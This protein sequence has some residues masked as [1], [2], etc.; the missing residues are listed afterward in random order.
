MAK[1]QLKIEVNPNAE[2]EKL[3]DITNKVDGTGTN[4]NLSNVSIKANDRGLY[5][6]G[7]MNSKG[8]ELLSFGEDGNL[9]F[10]QSGYLSS[11]GKDVGMLASEQKPDMFVWGVVPSNK[12]YNVKL[13]FTNAQNL[14]DIV[15]YGDRVANQFPTEAIIDNDKVIYNDDYRWAINLLTESDTHTIEFTKWNRSDYNACLTLVRVMLRYFDISKDSGLIEVES[16]S[17]SNSQPKDIYYGVIPNTGS[18]RVNDIGGE[19]KDLIDEGIIT[20]SKNN[21][22]IF[23]DNQK[24]QHHITTDSDYEDGKVFTMEFENSLSFLETKYAGRN[25]T[26]PMSAYALLREVLRTLNYTINQIDSMLDKEIVYGDNEIGSVKS[27]LEKITIEYPYLES[28][29]YRET[30]DKFCVLAQLNLLEDDNG[31]LK[32]VSARPVEPKNTD[33]IVIPANKQFANF[34]KDEFLKNKFNK[35]F[36]ETVEYKGEPQ[37]FGETKTAI[38]IEEGLSNNKGTLEDGTVYDYSSYTEVYDKKE[39]NIYAEST[40]KETK[41]ISGLIIEGYKVKNI[42]LP[43]PI[44]YIVKDNDDIYINITADVKNRATA[45]NKE[46]KVVTTNNWSGVRRFTDT[47]NLRKSN[48]GSDFWNIENIKID[49]GFVSFDL[50]CPSSIRWDGVTSNPAIYSE[51]YGLNVTVQLYGNVYQIK[52]IT[53]ENEQDIEISGNE[54]IQ[55]G[56]LYQ[57]RKIGEL[58]QNNIVVDY[59]RGIKTANTTVA[60]LDYYN[61]NGDKAIDWSKQEIFKVG[62]IVRVDKDNLGNSKLN[63]INGQP[64]LWKITGRNFRYKGVPMLDLELQEVKLNT[65]YTISESLALYARPKYTRVESEYGG[66]LGEISKYDILYPYDKIKI[67]YSVEQNAEYDTAKAYVN[68]ELISNGQIITVEGNVN[69]TIVANAKEYSIMANIGEGYEVN[70]ERVASYLANAPLGTMSV[71]DKFYASDVLELT[72]KRKNV[73]YK[74]VEAYFNNE[75]IYENTPKRVSINR[76][77]TLNVVTYKINEEPLIWEGNVEFD[78]FAYNGTTQSTS[79]YIN[80]LLGENIG[81][82]KN[83]EMILYF[84]GFECGVARDLENTEYPGG[85]FGSDSGVMEYVLGDTGKIYASDIIKNTGGEF[86]EDP[87][88]EFELGYSSND[89]VVIRILREIGEWKDEYDAQQCIFTKFKLVKVVQH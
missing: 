24:V 25:L 35:V 52:R 42:L 43:I 1:V 7:E 77:S 23:I 50:F 15:V 11:N 22:E 28:A 27:Y 26:E 82:N 12:A 45:I 87:T 37:L 29:T 57:G 6:V 88:I 36:V 70:I 17:Q 9:V 33:V 41:N 40:V 73:E 16:L 14:K 30:L 56:T 79:I 62:Q 51:V 55:E 48:A 53:S 69:L 78:I 81:F 80:E 39:S 18:A 20:N 86:I 10:T 68:G 38:F 13:T 67:E 61:T 31:N 59:T 83:K 5:K 34:R 72:L 60:C 32:F 46:S 2:T 84:E 89:E 47:W 64:Y 21:I 8:R 66:S 74:L 65:Y 4:A 76:N 44:E 63:Y 75:R 19:I 58:N 3:G 71:N 85:S 49:N 54:L